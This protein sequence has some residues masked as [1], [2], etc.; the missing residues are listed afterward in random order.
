MGWCTVT[1]FEPSGKVPSTC[2]SATISGTPSI[3]CARPSIRRPR[4]ISSATL[5]P[6]RMSSSNWVAMSAIASG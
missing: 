1:S 2:T 5:R 4:S 3:T 6:S